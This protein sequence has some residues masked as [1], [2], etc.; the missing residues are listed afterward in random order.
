MISQITL[1]NFQSHKNTTLNFH[2]HINLIVGASDSGKTAVIRAINWLVNNR[3]AGDSFRSKFGKTKTDETYVELVT[4]NTTLLRYKSDK[5]N[6]YSVGLDSFKAMGQNVPDE[7]SAELNMSNINIQYQMDSPFLL[8]ESSGEVARYF[9][10]IVNLEKIDQSLKNADSRV[11]KL[12]QS[13]Q[14]NEQEL[15]KQTEAIKQYSWIEQAQKDF[16]VIEKYAAA[17]KE[18]RQKYTQL[19]LLIKIIKEYQSHKYHAIDF[20]QAESRLLSIEELLADTD[21]TYRRKESLGLL[22]FELKNASKAINSV[23]YEKAEKNLDQIFFLNNSWT[24]LYNKVSALESIKEDI[25]RENKKLMKIEL[26]IQDTEAV[27]KQIMPDVCPLCGQE[28]HE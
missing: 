21:T 18:A 5:E 22:L 3:P 11:R 15:E 9:N 13:I 16:K 7:V 19:S 8:S 1:H 10:K 27:L 4:K 26:K 25:Q 28:I 6:G 12:N 2:E 20:K 14:F 24:D 23:D 17:E